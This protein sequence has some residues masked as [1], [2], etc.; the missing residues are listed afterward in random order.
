MFGE[1]CSCGVDGGMSKVLNIISSSGLVDDALE[2]SCVTFSALIPSLPA[3]YSPEARI[4][5]W[6]RLPLVLLT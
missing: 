6:P 4:T 2:G 5:A 3:L 1:R